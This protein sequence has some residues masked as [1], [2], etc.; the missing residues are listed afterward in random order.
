MN[1]EKKENLETYIG[2][3]EKELE[4]GFVGIIREVN[5]ITNKLFFGKENSTYEEREGYAVTVEIRGSGEEFTQWFSKPNIRGYEQSNIF[6]F[7]QKYKSIPKKSLEVECI[8][9]ENGFFRIKF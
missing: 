2:E 4:E 7:K 6:A 3:I 5:P 8:I 9:D 1:E